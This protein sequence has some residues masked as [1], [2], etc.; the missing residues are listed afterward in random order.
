MLSGH[1]YFVDRLVTS[2]TVGAVAALVWALADPDADTVP[3]A[4]LAQVGFAS[5]RA[6]Q[7]L[8]AAVRAEFANEFGDLPVGTFTPAISVDAFAEAIRV[9]L[10]AGEL[11]EPALQTPFGADRTAT[12]SV[13]PRSPRV[14]RVG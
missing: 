10:E 7:D 13:G 4:T 6:V 9:A 2:V 5:T 12:G 8:A 14:D 11:T 3:N 1:W